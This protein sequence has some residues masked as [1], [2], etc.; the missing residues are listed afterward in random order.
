MPPSAKSSNRSGIRKVRTARLSD[1]T[2]V[3]VYVK[4]KKARRG[5]KPKSKPVSDVTRNNR[6]NEG[7]KTRG[8]TQ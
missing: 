4:D 1:G 7:S 5:S 3:N 8:K 2:I 6:H